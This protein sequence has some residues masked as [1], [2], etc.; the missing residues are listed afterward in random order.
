MQLFMTTIPS[1]LWTCTTAHSTVAVAEVYARGR[2]L[3]GLPRAKGHRFELMLRAPAA[4]A[5][6]AVASA[7]VVGRMQGSR[8]RL[9][10]LQG[11]GKAAVV[12]PGCRTAAADLG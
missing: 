5:A 3:P 1:R 8:R 7:A 2:Q 10:G 9:Q 4:V 12:D 11:T 6:E